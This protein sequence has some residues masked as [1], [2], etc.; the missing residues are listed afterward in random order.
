MHSGF[1]SFFRYWNKIRRCL[2]QV[3]K[4]DPSANQLRVTGLSAESPQSHACCQFAEDLT[5]ALGSVC[6]D[7]R[8][9]QGL[10]AGAL[11]SFG[12]SGLTLVQPFSVLTRS[13]LFQ[14]GSVV[15]RRQCRN[16][17]RMFPDEITGPSKP[18]DRSF[19]KVL[20]QNTVKEFT[21]LS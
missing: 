5:S 21:T 9:G 14:R 16:G 7:A 12:F 15:H 17:S 20:E 8:A 2:R 11:L 19:I 18:H 6:P 1:K 13:K 10:E 3:V 4:F